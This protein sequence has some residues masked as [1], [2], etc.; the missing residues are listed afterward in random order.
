MSSVTSFVR[1][2]PITSLRTYFDKSGIELR[3]AVNWNASESEVVGPLL[4]AV[5]ELDDASRERLVHDADRVTAMADEP[6]Q[7]ALYN[8][9]QD[10][11]RL[12]S[13]RKL[14]ISSLLM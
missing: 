6:G 8:V 1:N 12:E 3:P 9:V 14:S 5:E 7:T 2:T 11:E 4:R 13:L 10:Q